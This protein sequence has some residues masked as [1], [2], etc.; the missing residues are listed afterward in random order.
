MDFPL[1]ATIT[2][3]NKRNHTFYDTITRDGAGVRITLNS[4]FSTNFFLLEIDF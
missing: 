1:Q 3:A 2:L 4:Y